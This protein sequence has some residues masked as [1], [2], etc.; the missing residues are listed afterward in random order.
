MKSILATAASII[1]MGP[2]PGSNV[3]EIPGLP[4]KSS[5]PVKKVRRN[6]AIKL[7]S[8]ICGGGTRDTRSGIRMLPED[9]NYPPTQGLSNYDRAH[10]GRA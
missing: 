8:G 9:G 7:L 3:K 5:K 10:Y 6:P 4:S 1:G 2:K